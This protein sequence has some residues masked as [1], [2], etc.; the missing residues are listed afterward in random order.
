MTTTELP[1]QSAVRIAQA[2]AAKQVS[3]VEVVQAYLDRIDQLGDTL[4]AYITVCREAALDA[5]ER[6]EQ[7]VMRGEASGSLFGVPTAVKD[8]FWTQGLLTTNGSRVYRDFVPDDDATIIARL[9]Q[10]GTILLG[11][12]NLSELAMG[13]TRNPP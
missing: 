6:A 8:Q 1:F 10:A 3:P 9:A 5:A 11:K 2:I 7:A 4:H 12:L 13:G